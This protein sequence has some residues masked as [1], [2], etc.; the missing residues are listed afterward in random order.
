MAFPRDILEM[1]SKGYVFENDGTC[2][3]CGEDIEW[4][5]TPGGSKIPMNPMPTSSTAAVAHFN[6]CSDRK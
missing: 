3:D 2:R 4:W 6:T 5:T 1:K